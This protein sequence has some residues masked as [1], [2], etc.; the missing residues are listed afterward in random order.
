MQAAG[1]VFINQ[2]GGF[3]GQRGKTGP[4]VANSKVLDTVAGGGAEADNVMGRAFT[5][6][7]GGG[8]SLN[9]MV[10][11]AGVFAGILWNPLEHSTAGSGG[12]ALA[13]TDTIP[14]GQVADFV[15]TVPGV[16]VFLVNNGAAGQAAIGNYVTFD[17]V[18]GELRS[19]NQGTALPAG[20]TQIIGAAVTELS[21]SGKAGGNIAMIELG[22]LNHA[23]P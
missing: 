10:G 9:V 6:I 17:D 13:P 23:N 16:W 20:E 8:D 1:S 18:T 21:V 5:Q 2:T 7:S 15:T 19:H 12:S 4:T 3:V 14:D 22:N 11:G